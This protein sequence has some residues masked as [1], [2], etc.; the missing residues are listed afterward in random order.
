MRSLL[1][2]TVS[3]ISVV[4]LTA[5]GENFSVANVSLG[6]SGS[7]TQKPLPGGGNPPVTGDKGKDDEEEDQYDY[8]VTFPDA[9]NDECTGIQRSIYFIDAGTK[10][11]QIAGAQQ[12]SPSQTVQINIKNTTPNYIFE[13]IPQCHQVEFWAMSG[14]LHFLPDQYLRCSAEQYTV[15]VLQ[16]YEIKTYEFD[17]KIPQGDDILLVRYP[18]QYTSN[19]PDAQT[20]WSSCPTLDIHLP[21]TQQLIPKSGE[22][23]PPSKPDLSEPLSGRK[24]QQ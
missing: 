18:T 12:S 4:V 8:F 1:L 11:P 2:A 17:F 13:K 23:L 9:V 3:F 22:K 16:P 20:H 10:H 15:Q 6:G 14:K 7:G 21:V 24:P 5:C 19:L